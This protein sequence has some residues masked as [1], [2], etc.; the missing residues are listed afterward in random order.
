MEDNFY[1]NRSSLG[2]QGH[3]TLHHLWDAEKGFNLLCLS[4]AFKCCLNLNA[5]LPP[6]FACVQMCWCQQ[7]GTSHELPSLPPQCDQ[8]FP[9]LPGQF[10]SSRDFPSASEVN[11]VIAKMMIV[12]GMQMSKVI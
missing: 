4:A 12:T 2:P 1:T 5:F 7:A 3:A 6:A 11:A 10:S 8:N 9:P